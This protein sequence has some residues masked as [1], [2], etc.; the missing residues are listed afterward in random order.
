MKF[1]QEKVIGELHVTW[2]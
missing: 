2:F 1:R